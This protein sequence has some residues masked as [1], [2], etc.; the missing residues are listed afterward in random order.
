MTRKVLNAIRRVL[1][2]GIAWRLIPVV[3]PDT[4]SVD[5]AVPVLARRAGPSPPS[6]DAPAR[7]T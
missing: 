5:G 4:Q 1:R 3:M 6:S 7:S 2:G